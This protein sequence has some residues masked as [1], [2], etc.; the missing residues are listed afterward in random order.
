M[1]MNKFYRMKT[2]LKKKIKTDE[3][4]EF[5]SVFDSLEKVNEFSTTVE[6]G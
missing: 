6:A 5:T 4:V 1:C 3:E 2:E